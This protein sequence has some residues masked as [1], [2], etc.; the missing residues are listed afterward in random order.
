MS[1]FT[2]TTAAAGHASTSLISNIGSLISVKLENHNYLLWKSQF[3]PVLRAYGL[4]GF[5]D[6]SIMCPSEFLL[7]SN[8]N[9]TKDVNPHY[10]SWIQQ[11]QNV[12][13]WINAT[14]FEGVLAHVVGLK[15]ARNVWEALERRFASL[16]WS[17]VIQLK[18]QLQNIKRGALTVTE[19]MKKIKHISDS[20]AAVLSPV[21]EEDLIIH[22]LNGLPPD[23][24]AFRT[25]IRTRASPLSI[26]ELHVLLLCEEMS[27]ESSQTTSSDYTTT[28]FTASKE[29]GKSGNGGRGSYKPNGRG[30]NTNNRG[31]NNNIPEVEAPQISL[32][33][34]FSIPN[35]VAKSA[36]ERGILRL[37]VTIGWT[38]LSKGVILRL[39]WLQWLHLS[40]VAMILPGMQ[41]RVPQTIFLMI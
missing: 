32:L 27:L 11:D 2:S 36:T 21:D 19:Y 23:Y 39:N 7:D 26:E 4:V 30:R 15:T 3:L 40:I 18:T 24:A 8:E 6:G 34:N 12:L 31:R 20:L 29:S 35:S 9:P 1:A 5:V 13:C 37:I 22:T 16:S 17:R 38:I 41:I 14:L 10:S 28:A 25:S 33:N